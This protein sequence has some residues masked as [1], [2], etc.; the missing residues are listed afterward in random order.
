MWTGFTILQV[1]AVYLGYIGVIL[2]CIVGVLLSSS[3]IGHVAGSLGG[4]VGALVE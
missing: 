3:D 2:L 4:P 1:I